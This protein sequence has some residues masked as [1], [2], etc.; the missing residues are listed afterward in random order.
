MREQ[1]TSTLWVCD[2]GDCENSQTL[3]GGYQNTPPQGWRI[4]EILP[5]NLNMALKPPP[6]LTRELLS[7]CPNCFNKLGD[8]IA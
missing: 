3:T 6:D 5:V 1:T 4:I 8:L 7:L 2:G